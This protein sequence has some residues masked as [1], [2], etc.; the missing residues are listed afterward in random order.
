MCSTLKPV[1]YIPD[2]QLKK[3]VE[4]NIEVRLKL[5]K[6]ACAF[7]DF[8]KKLYKKC[9]DDFLFWLEH[10]CYSYDPRPNAI[11]SN[12]PFVPYEFQKEDCLKIIE[13]INRGEDV[14]VEKSR[15][16]GFTWLVC[17]VFQWFW[18]FHL[19]S[20]F[21][22]GS[23]KLDNVDKQG[24]PSCIF[25]KIRFNIK[26][27]PA[28]LLPKCFDHNKH[29][30]FSRCVNPENGNAI[31]GESSNA[32]FG[33]SGRYKAVLFDEFAFWEQG[34]LAWGACSQSTQCRIALSTPFGKANKFGHLRFHSP[35]KVLTRHWTSH[36]R[37]TKN[38]ISLAD[39]SFS[40]DWYLEE[41][42][43]MTSAEVARE[44][45]IDYLT[46][47][48]GAVYR[49]NR[50]IHVQDNLK[51]E[52]LSQ[53][54]DTIYRIWDFGLN[55]AVIFA[56]NTPYGARILRELTPDDRPTT[57]KLVTLVEGFSQKEFS[58]CKFKD[59]CDVAGNQTNR[60]TSKTDIEILEESGIYPENDFIPIEDGITA[61]QA[62][63]D[64][65]D[66]VIIDSKCVNTIEAF[67]GGYF[68][69]EDKSGEGKEMQPTEIHPYEDVM[70]CVRYHIWRYFRPSRFTSKTKKT[71]EV[72]YMDCFIA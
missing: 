6:I 66:G 33:R 4:N 24:D 30:V 16:M 52:I 29:L 51:E 1:Q 49:F 64:R 13:Q 15:D 43:R 68:R 62:L 58:N 61:V 28:F 22:I 5:L 56:A 3:Q 18:Q 40:S 17:F 21:L 2:E 70:D 48:E 69:K 38:L 42:Q 41:K 47:R 53:N 63:L 45:D 19:G 67:E 12:F 7:P 72:K 59:I 31:I 8:Q 36:P 65:P 39:G 35:I 20:N 71:N 10:F 46:S 37:K 60:Q 26:K 9:S 11:K 34:Q 57:S 55:P 25:E 50:R 23:K 14:L 32:D 27:Q 44:L 54:T